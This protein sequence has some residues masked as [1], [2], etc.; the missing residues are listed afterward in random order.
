[1]G[2]TLLM[3]KKKE[4][5][6]LLIFVFLALW[7]FCALGSIHYYRKGVNIDNSDRERMSAYFNLFFLNVPAGLLFMGSGPLAHSKVLIYSILI[8]GSFHDPL[9]I[10]CMI[11][12]VLK[13]LSKSSG[14]KMANLG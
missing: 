11:Y 1:M 7:L 8:A 2:G 5:L 9:I 12:Y 10:I 14:K 4:L 13:K 3:T 6:H